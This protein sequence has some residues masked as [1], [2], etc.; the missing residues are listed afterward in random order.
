[1]RRRRGKSVGDEKNLL[2]IKQIIERL[3]QIRKI[4]NQCI[5]EIGSTPSKQTGLRRSKQEV[6]EVNFTELNFSLNVRAF[7]KKYA[8][9]LSG[10]KKFVLIL[11]YLAKGEIK[12][13]ISLAD[14][15]KLWQ[16]MTG[17][18]GMEFNRSYALRAKDYGWVN[19][20]KQGVYILTNSWKEISKHE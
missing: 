16:R 5:L 11:A 13:G 19:S 18:I 6:E 7:V 1:L 14:I 12:K 9:Q 17:L 2:K 8:K 10:P 15:E 20:I 4:A 3:E